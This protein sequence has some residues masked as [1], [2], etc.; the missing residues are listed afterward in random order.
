VV[1]HLRLG[2]SPGHH[3]GEWLDAYALETTLGLGGLWS[4]NNVPRSLEPPY[5]GDPEGR[6]V[7][8]RLKVG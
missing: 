8:L 4:K 5:G 1:H 3:S 2:P 7:F 6:M